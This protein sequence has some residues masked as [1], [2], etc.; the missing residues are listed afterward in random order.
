MPRATSSQAA[1]CARPPAREAAEKTTNPTM[2]TRRRPSRSAA[3]PPSSRNPPNVSVYA[4]TTQGRLASEKCS[5]VLIDGSATLTIDASSTTMNWA[6]HRRI[7]ARQRRGSAVD[8]APGGSAAVKVAFPA[9]R[10]LLISDIYGPPRV[11][12]SQ[13][14]RHPGDGDA[15]SPDP[16]D[17]LVVSHH[18]GSHT[19]V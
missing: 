2:N 7:R 15:S 12:N 19:D 3:R 11:D 16:G 13:R 8:V 9:A 14:D 18:D 4:F 10:P 6:A 1:D 5:A 17:W